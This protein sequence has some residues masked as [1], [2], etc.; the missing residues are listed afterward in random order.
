MVKI[1]V[2]TTRLRNSATPVLVLLWRDC[3]IAAH[4]LKTSVGVA[5]EKEDAAALTS[6]TGNGVV[7][8]AP[9]LLILKAAAHGAGAERF[10]AAGGSSKTATENNC[11]RRL[12]CFRLEKTRKKTVAV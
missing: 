12:F 5:L 8:C 11:L 3:T 6:V 10:A 2:Q 4:G 9:W 1:Q 7:V